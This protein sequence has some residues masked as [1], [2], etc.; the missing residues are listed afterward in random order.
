VFGLEKKAKLGEADFFGSTVEGDDEDEEVADSGT[1]EYEGEDKLSSYFLNWPEG[2]LVVFVEWLTL[3]VR[4]KT[5]LSIFETKK[6]NFY[7][8]CKSCMNWGLFSIN[9]LINNFFC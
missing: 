4:I 1:S 9:K 6:R 5:E 7:P 2:R 8:Q 3:Y